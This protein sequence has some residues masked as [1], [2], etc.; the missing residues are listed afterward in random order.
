MVATKTLTRAII[1]AVVVN[2]FTLHSAVDLLRFTAEMRTAVVGGT[3][4]SLRSRT[5]GG[6]GW[7]TQ[8]HTNT[9][10]PLP[11]RRFSSAQPLTSPSSSSASSASSTSFPSSVPPPPLLPSQLPHNLYR[12][13]LRVS[14]DSDE[15]PLS[16]HA[17]ILDPPGRV[18]PTSSLIFLHGLGESPTFLRP[19]FHAVRLPHTRVVVPRAPL[20]PITGLDEMEERT[21]FDLLHPTIGEGTTAE[22]EEG[23]DL[24]AEKVRQLIEEEVARG[25]PY[26]RIVLMGVAQGGAMAVHVGMGMGEGHQLGGVGVVSGYLALRGRYP[27][28]LTEAGRRTPLLVLHGRADRAIEWD[29]ARKGWEALEKEGV[30]NI[31]RRVEHSMNHQLTHLQFAQLMDWVQQT[32]PVLTPHSPTPTS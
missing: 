28:R 22:D 13:P 31:E 9:S 19:L 18:R 11:L 3:Q 8:R 20:L 12:S 14:L 7:I 10:S 30:K 17:L 25:I 4:C 27:Q 15:G 5:T 29:W 32:L 16:S 2:R 1:E 24:M 26:H 6:R 23:I 21:W